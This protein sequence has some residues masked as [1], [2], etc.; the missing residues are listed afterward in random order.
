[1]EKAD[2]AIDPTPRHVIPLKFYLRAQ[3]EAPGRSECG[4]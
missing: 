3:R 1:M 2:L 4:A